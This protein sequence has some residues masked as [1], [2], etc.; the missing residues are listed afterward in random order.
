MSI[1]IQMLYDVMYMEVIL[2]YGSRCQL[3]K[4]INSET[5]REPMTYKFS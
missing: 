4:S 5:I 2:Y 1:V 3:G